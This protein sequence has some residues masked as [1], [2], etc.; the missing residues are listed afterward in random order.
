MVQIW[1]FSPDPPTPISSRRLPRKPRPAAVK[2]SSTGGQATPHACGRSRLYDG[3]IR[4]WLKRQDLVYYGLRIGR[5]SGFAQL[6]AAR[7]GLPATSR[8][9]GSLVG[10]VRGYG[11]KADRIFLPVSCALRALFFLVASSDQEESR[12]RFGIAPAAPSEGRRRRSPP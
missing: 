1:V 5:V 8:G 9:V 6:A 12:R 4:S 11:F 10:S 2:R 7:R 3:Q